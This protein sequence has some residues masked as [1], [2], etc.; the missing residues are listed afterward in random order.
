MDR[1][2]L[3]IIIT[4]VGDRQRCRQLVG[5]VLVRAG[6]HATIGETYGAFSAVAR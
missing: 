3:N 5:K 2:P 4:G 1:E 6:F